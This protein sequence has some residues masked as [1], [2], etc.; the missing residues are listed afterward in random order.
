MLTLELYDFVAADVLE[1]VLVRVQPV[2]HQSH[3]VTGEEVK[4]GQVLRVGHFAECRGVAGD[5]S[6][7]VG[8]CR[9]AEVPACHLAHALYFGW[10]VVVAFRVHHA[11]RDPDHGSDEADCGHYPGDIDAADAAAVS[12]GFLLELGGGHGGVDADHGGYFARVPVGI[13]ECVQ[14]PE[15]VSSQDV[16]FLDVE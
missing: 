5:V 15:R 7:F 12:R 14:A 1:L 10:G 4:N 13:V 3:A 16:W 11:G 6:G 9:V 2:G 8:Y